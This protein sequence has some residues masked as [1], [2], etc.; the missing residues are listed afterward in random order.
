MTFLTRAAFGFVA[1]VAT[2]IPL[3]PQQLTYGQMYQSRPSVSP[4]GNLLAFEHDPSPSAHDHEV[5][6]LDL[7]ETRA[8]AKVVKEIQ[9]ARGMSWS[10]DGKWL[11]YKGHD[12]SADQVFK[13]EIDS[14]K[15][16]QLTDFEPGTSLKNTC[17]SS[18]G[19]IVFVRGSAVYSVD[20]NT[21]KVAVILTPLWESEPLDPDDIS[22]SPDGSK[23]ALSGLIYFHEE[24]RDEETRIWW[25]DL[26]NQEIHLLTSG[27][28]DMSPSWVDND[29]VIFARFDESMESNTI[30]LAKIGH[31]NT[32]EVFK[33]NFYIYPSVDPGR[34]T[35]F[36]SAAP[37]LT[38]RGDF[39]I[40]R[41][42]HIWKYPGIRDIGQQWFEDLSVRAAGSDGDE[43]RSVSL[44]Q[45]VPA[46]IEGR[47]EAPPG[48]PAAP[49]PAEAP[50]AV[51]NSLGMEFVRIP[52]GEFGMGSTSSEVRSD[53]QPVTRVTISRA[54]YMGR[55]EVTQGQWEAVMGSNPSHFEECGPDCPVE[56]V[57]WNEVQEFIGKL[58]AM[59]GEAPHRLPTEAEWEYAAR[60]GTGGDR[61]GSDLDVIAWYSGN[62]GR[63]T[64]AVGG[65]APNGYGLHDMLGNVWE[66]VQDWHGTYPGDA[67]TDPQGPVSGLDRV[68]RGGGWTSNAEYCRASH[69]LEFPPDGIKFRSLGFRLV[70]T[71][72]VR[73]NPLTY[74]DP[75]GQAIELTDKTEEE[76]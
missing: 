27:A 33:N 2:V 47:Q 38:L 64:H 39:E 16:V 35:V 14:D 72:Y 23:L 37:K 42:F 4:D 44:P 62:S 59:P 28:Q 21:R 58:N 63:R 8:S 11:S 9:D 26:T 1:V 73:N 65:K 30:R 43:E 36:A 74:I 20:P 68:L 18:T 40:F 17:W 41:D 69:R 12:G 53:E 50:A 56:L 54:F 31:H 51:R 29:T 24:D 5:L 19:L 13:I 67:G 55:Y 57:T 15:P 45:Q 75:T 71:S 3:L 70:R 25:S 34:K 66:W 7:R 60:A 46:E 61:F 52:V 49:R 32:I 6:V 76:R 22:L 10:P 48:A